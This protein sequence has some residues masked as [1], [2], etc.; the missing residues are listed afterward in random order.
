MIINKKLK[1]TLII[2]LIFIFLNHSFSLATSDEIE[3]INSSQALI[4]KINEQKKQVQKTIK[5]LNQL[6]NDTEKF[7]KELD[8]SLEQLVTELNLTIEAIDMKQNEIDITNQDLLIAKT[9]EEKQYEDMKKRIVFFYERDN[10][11]MLENIMEGNNLVDALT[12]AEYIQNITDYDRNKLNQLIETKNQISE[13]EEKLVT[14]KNELVNL[15]DAETAQKESIEL[16]LFE[17]QKE[18]QD[19]NNQINKSTK[20]LKKLEADIKAQED[21]I[22]AIEKAIEE[23]ERASGQKRVLKGGLIWPLPSSNRITSR[24]GKRSKPTKGASSYHQGIDIGASTGEKVIA[25]ASGEVVI[26]KY[27]YS[28]GNYIMISHGSQIYTVYMHLS[29]RS[30]NEGD[31]VV[32]GQKIG[33]VGSTGYSTGPHLHFGIRKNGQYVDPL[34]FVG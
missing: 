1:I 32:L 20:E 18:V 2:C 9:N 13:L 31:T 8:M 27:S 3:K 26:S 16:L 14:E 34:T 19:T 29:K 25:A 28:G 12:R 11:S 21:N 4:R 23:R 30:V 5:N 22:I 10:T 17:K 24:F 33:E 6:K 7:I 15:K